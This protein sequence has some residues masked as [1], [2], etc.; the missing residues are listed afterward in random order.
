MDL[1]PKTQENG[2]LRIEG[3]H[4]S[5]FWD[6]DPKTQ[7]NC[8]FLPGTCP[9]NLGT[10]NKKKR[11]QTYSYTHN[12][13]E[14]MV[15]LPG[16]CPPP[17]VCGLIEVRRPLRPGSP[18]CMKKTCFCFVKPSKAWACSSAPRACSSAHWVYSSEPW[19]CISAHWACGSRHWASSSA[20][21]LVLPNTLPASLHIKYC[22]KSWKNKK[23]K[24]NQ[25]QLK[26]T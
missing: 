16:T 14:H 22:P 12:S 8:V 13:Q 5:R 11:L 2:V 7:D 1:D 10:C 4:G 26:K 23:T 19:A 15:F 6:R 17:L 25:Q 18:K 20:L 24:T 3:S 9:P 21:W